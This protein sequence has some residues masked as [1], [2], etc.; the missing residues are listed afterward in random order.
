MTVAWQDKEGL[1]FLLDV[2]QAVVEWP[3]RARSFC[4]N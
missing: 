2:G 4:L 3:Y 1:D